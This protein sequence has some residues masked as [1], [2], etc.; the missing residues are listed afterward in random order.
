MPVD[1]KNHILGPIFLGVAGITYLGEVYG[2]W[3]ADQYYQK[4]K[5]IILKL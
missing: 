4:Q 1:I 5:T 3:R 2:A